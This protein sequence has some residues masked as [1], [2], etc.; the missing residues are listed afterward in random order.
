MQYNNNNYKWKPKIITGVPGIGEIPGISE[1]KPIQEVQ[2]VRQITTW[3]QLQK[4][5]DY[6]KK[7][8]YS[9]QF[10]AN[11]N[12]P[13]ELNSYLDALVNRKAVSKEFGKAWGTVSTISGTVAVL[14]F[15]V[16]AAL[17]AAAFFTGGATAGPAVGFA[18]TGATAAAGAAGVGAGAGTLGG[19]ASSAAASSAAASSAAASSA[20]AALSTAARTAIKV[21]AV[22]SIPAIPAA[23][24]VTYDYG[25]KPIMYGKPDQAL[26]NTMMNLGETMDFAA[27]P[28]KGL[29]MEGPQ[30][31]LKATGLTDAGRVNYDYDT[32]N[33]II[34]MLL[35]IVSDPMNWIEGPA[36][37]AKGTAI[38]KTAKN[39][40]ES[41]IKN[42]SDATIAV[43][44][45]ITEDSATKAFKALTSG[46]KELSQDVTEKFAKGKLSK[47]NK[48]L[49]FLQTDVFTNNALTK[50]EIKALTE[51]SQH[52][53]Y[54]L[55]VNYIK[56]IAPDATDIDIENILTKAGKNI[57]K[58]STLGLNVLTDIQLDDLS[59]S[60]IRALHGIT[61][62]TDMTQKFM[63]RNALA[64]PI[65]GLGLDISKYYDKP[66]LE[67]AAK[68]TRKRLEKLRY[69]DPGLGLTDL[70][71]YESFKNTLLNTFK[72]HLT[73]VNEVDTLT[74]TT[75]N[76][77]YALM[78]SQYGRDKYLIETALAE[79][80]NKP[81][82]HAAA[83]DAIIQETYG[84]DFNAYVQFLE[85]INIT[86]GGIY[87]AYVQHAQAV[88]KML[89]RTSTAVGADPTIIKVEAQVYAKQSIDKWVTKSKELYE[90]LNKASTADIQ[91]HPEKMIEVIYEFKQS[92]MVLNAMFMNDP[93]YWPIITSLAEGGELNNILENLIKLTTAH[94]R[95]K[96]FKAAEAD[97]I[98]Q[99]ED[100]FI[101]EYEALYN[102]LDKAENKPA[103]YNEKVA[104]RL[105]LKAEEAVKQ[106][107][108]EIRKQALKNMPKYLKDSAETFKLS[109]SINKLS[110]EN[111]TT[112][113]KTSGI[114][115]RITTLEYFLNTTKQSAEG[116][117]HLKTLYNNMDTLMLPKIEGV[118]DKQL[119]KYILYSLLDTSDN[120]LDA[121]GNYDN[122]VA[123]AFYKLNSLLEDKNFI[124]T[125]YPEVCEQIKLIYKDYLTGLQNLGIEKINDNTVTNF[126]KRVKNCVASIDRECDPKVIPEQLKALSVSVHSMEDLINMSKHAEELSGLDNIKYMFTTENSIFTKAFQ[127]E[128]IDAD[129]VLAAKQQAKGA[130]L[131][132]AIPATVAIPYAQQ[133]IKLGNTITGMVERFTKHNLKM[134]DIQTK[135]IAQLF[136]RL[137]ESF[138]YS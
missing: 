43:G 51:S 73:K 67:W 118:N 13:E 34:D 53:I 76:S 123:N 137:Q 90:K 15:I 124:V 74:E 130:A 71:K 36:N 1:I 117:M 113:A 72:Y 95:Y 112:L 24:K 134:S 55:L 46:L 78:K 131:F 91:A 120:V 135:T 20:A 136:K 6:T 92:D 26:L 104:A 33:V 21:G 27:N 82:E 96:A 65:I 80:A 7:D 48:I 89:L 56:T 30:G 49:K 22:A 4:A 99:A 105:R 100:K 58:N 10:L 132:D 14:S 115:D 28:V 47:D 125:D 17:G 88:Q 12:D 101:A 98:K 109:L 126:I 77:F 59:T 18:K 102:A 11:Y 41:L 54:N 106:Q 103:A 66:L 81:I 122:T 94:D 35:E 111:Y 127:R 45:E 69:F 108:S 138:Y 85:K 133:M 87:D 52:K 116:Y 75:T 63:T 129:L 114:S 39:V 37:I 110:V 62:I 9:Q 42:I 2:P 3:D 70:A 57:S 79:H 84:V 68:N 107:H 40:A 19:F 44:K 23:A 60:T 31:F 16:A 121:L 61:E 119:R 32:G 50:E 83:I 86:E 128:L 38:A 93:D 25:I 97:V 29:V 64:S 8:K 5:Y